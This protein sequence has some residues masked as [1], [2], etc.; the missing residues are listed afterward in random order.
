[1]QEIHKGV[2][3][4]M[5]IESVTLLNQSK[6][7]RKINLPYLSRSQ[8]GDGLIRLKDNNTEGSNTEGNKAGL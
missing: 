8:K 5:H 7:Q 4:E 6:N 2:V 1:M 3:K